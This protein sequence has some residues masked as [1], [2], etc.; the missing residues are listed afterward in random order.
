MREGN[1]SK[2]QQPIGKNLA[3][4]A[5]P[6]TSGRSGPNLFAMSDGITIN[7][8]ADPGQRPNMVTLRQGTQWVQY[9]WSQPVNTKEIDLFWWSDQ[10][11]I[12]LPKSYRLLY[13]DGNTFVP[14]SNPA[15]L[16]LDAKQFNKTTFN[17]V[18][19]T[20]LRLEVDPDSTF[21][22]GIVEWAVI[23]SNKSPEFPAVI[24]AGVDRDVIAGG[25]TYLSAS[26]KS[27]TPLKKCIWT[28]DSGPGKVIF[29][30]AKATETTAIFTIPGEYILTFTGTGG[31]LKSSSSLKVKVVLPPPGER[32]NVVYTKKYKI[33]S[34]LWNARAKAIIVNWIP[35]CI[36][37]IER[38]DLKIGPG[39]LDNFIEAGKALRG[40]THGKHLGYVFSNAWV[41]QTVE[42]MSIALMV[43]PQ[44][45]KN[46][47][48]AQQKM[49]TTLEKWIPI[50]LAAQEPDG[51]L[52]TAF[53]LR[54]TARWKDRWAPRTRGNHE[55]YVAGYFLESAI[56]HYTLTEGKDK[57]LYDA[58]KKL[59][60][61]W[62]ANIGPGKKEWYDGHQEM[63]QALVRFGRFVNDMEGNG[64]GDAYIALSKFLLDCRKNGTEY[65]Q[66]QVPV[67]QQY[68]AVG[69]AVRA[70]YSYS[71]MADIAAETGDVD[72]QSAVMSLWDNIVNKKYYITGGIGSGETSEGFGPNYSL[73]NN[74]YCESCSSCGLIFFQYK[75]NIA[76]HDAKYADLYEETLYNA[77]LG[78]LDLDGK[79][80]T[81][82][83]ELNSS[84]S[85]Y[86]WHVCPCCV[87]N[88]PR[89]LLMIP[90]WTYIKSDSGIYVNLFIGSTINVERVAGTDIEMIQKTDYPWSG[91]VSIVV[92]PKES[93]GFTVY[94]RVPNRTTSELYTPTPA[95]SGLLSLKVNGE[96][97]S[98]EIK[99]GYAVLKRTWKAGDKIDMSIPMDVQTVV[100]DNRIVADRDKV[101]LR[102]GP[103]VYNVEEIDQKNIRQPISKSP[104][105]AEWRKD[106]LGGVMT[107]KGTWA[108]GSPLLAIPNYARNNRN[109]KPVTDD[110][111]GS[112]VWI[113][114]K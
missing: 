54:D 86:G 73:R 13:W 81:Y 99:N 85:R 29:A 60:D 101:A 64:H 1:Q 57:R 55:G 84:R 71:G 67:Q 104:L 75:M 112:V 106:L 24:N 30:N 21:S 90:T 11:R 47:I 83:N 4:V 17:E 93:K 70:A 22:T 95:V 80:F 10:N 28:V 107:I 110:S 6:S 69:H 27:V 39:G 65:D 78:D 76:Y 113:K 20:R 42:A 46:I 43:D 7:K 52:Q 41:H 63:E 15:G 89:T 72:Y 37:Q 62:V 111:E 51:Y 53:T 3:V 40:E 36:T 50:I 58:A 9:E 87:G 26:V 25:K 105:T 35:H 61:C 91:N 77:L 114:S 98:P 14:V 19:T 79:N 33:D 31:K 38:T 108:D 100:A 45:D 48:A 23:A 97:F 32:L 88:I 103:L 8:L 56:N 12:R 92:N 94:V 16:G 49:K 34:P 82:T 2:D 68:E 109:P 18:Q 102:Y 66:S 59:A 44:G 5:I 74:A 96:S